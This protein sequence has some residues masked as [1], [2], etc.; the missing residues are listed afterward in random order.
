MP[1]IY[2]VRYIT[3]NLYVAIY[4]RIYSMISNHHVASYLAYKQLANI[5]Q[6][7]TKFLCN[8]INNV[9]MDMRNI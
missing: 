7:V 1:I 4:V 5:S 9:I 3:C 2:A 8:I 6:H